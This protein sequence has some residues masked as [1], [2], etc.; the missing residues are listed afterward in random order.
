MVGCDNAEGGTIILISMLMV[1][2]VRLCSDR[3]REGGR[4]GRLDDGIRWWFGKR[5]GAG[6]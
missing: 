5:T 6:E 2:G 1:V 3:G 4:L